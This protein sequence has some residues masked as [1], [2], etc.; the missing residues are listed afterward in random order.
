MTWF[1]VDDTLWAHPKW[2]KAPLRAR[3][4]WVTA[5]AWSASQL[6]DGVVPAHMLPMFGATKKDAYSLVTLNLWTE[7]HEN[8]GGWRFHDWEQYQPTRADVEEKR[9]I[10]RDRKRDYRRRS[11]GTYNGLSRRDTHG[12]P[13]GTPNGTPT[14]TPNGTPRGVPP[15]R[16]G[17]SRPVPPNPPSASTGTP[18]EETSSA[19][20]EGPR[21]DPFDEFWQAYPRK[22][23]QGAARAA[24]A[25]ATTDTPATTIV[26]G[27]VATLP[28]LQNV[29]PKFIP[30]PAK[31]IADERWTDTAAATNDPWATVPHANPRPTA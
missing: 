25:L 18:S 5:G 7:F 2:V 26:A 3:A 30:H 12:T 31:W 23:G 28:E 22:V 24:F 27:L 16:P 20:A 6:K 29:D 11:D 19:A 14:G 4:L 17:P 1:K 15:A 21:I 9:M 10:E 8:G 13:N